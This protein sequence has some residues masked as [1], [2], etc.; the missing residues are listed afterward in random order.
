M[1]M[2]PPIT[3]VLLLTNVAVFVL[4]TMTG[5]VLLSAFALWPPGMGF[6]PWQPI[7]YGFLHGNLAHLFFNMFAHS[8]PK[9]I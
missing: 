5:R 6:A 3:K 8:C 1:I 4:D 9:Q 7:T 2:V